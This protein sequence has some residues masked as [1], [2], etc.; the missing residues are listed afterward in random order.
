M[1]RILILMMFQMSLMKR[2]RHSLTAIPESASWSWW[3]GRQDRRQGE[4]PSGEA[5]GGGETSARVLIIE[6]VGG[7]IRKLVYFSFYFHI[8][9]FIVSLILSR[10]WACWL[11]G[12]N[13]L[14]WRW[15]C[16]ASW[17]GSLCQEGGGRPP[18]MAWCSLVIGNRDAVHHQGRLPVGL[19]DDG[20]T[21]QRNTGNKN[22]C[23]TIFLDFYTGCLKKSIHSWE[24]KL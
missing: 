17:G 14:P 18:F 15:W 13:S 24:T 10:H 11:S 19:H 16:L 7:I 6:E 2:D 20:S 3:R 12:N 23:Q 5:D 4:T 1:I 9:Y 21:A 8:L 22:I